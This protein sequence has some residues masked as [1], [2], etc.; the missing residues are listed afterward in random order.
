MFFLALVF[1]GVFI[2]KILAARDCLHYRKRRF[3][4]PF[5]SE[6]PFPLIDVPVIAEDHKAEDVAVLEPVS[7]A[8]LARADPINHCRGVTRI[9]P[10]WPDIEDAVGEPQQ[11]PA[12]GRAAAQLFACAEQTR[13]VVRV[14]VVCRVGA[15]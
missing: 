4:H 1:I 6:L 7:N 13:A 12:L 8:A 11:Q 10:V 3:K 2:G 5:G 15:L 14:W 9:F